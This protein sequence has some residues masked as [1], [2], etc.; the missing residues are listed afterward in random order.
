MVD[1]LFPPKF[2]IGLVMKPGIIAT[3]AMIIIMKSPLNFAIGFAIKS[4]ESSP[5]IG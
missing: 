3:I 4:N 5:A 2:A 1:S